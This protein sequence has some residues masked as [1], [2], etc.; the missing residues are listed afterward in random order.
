MSADAEWLISMLSTEY[1]LRPPRSMAAEAK[2]LSNPNSVLLHDKAGIAIGHAA[3]IRLGSDLELVCVVIA[4]EKR[5]TGLSHHL[6]QEVLTKRSGR[7]RVLCWTRSRSLASTLLVAGF[8][9][10]SWPGFTMALRVL[11]DR[12]RRVL[13]Q[14][15]GLHFG[16]LWHQTLHLGQYNLYV[17]E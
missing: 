5:G 9:R 2:Y 11:A 14:V 10:R 8:K 16:R 6:I 3:L 1:D 13:R 12:T 4:P 17:L 7:G 15:F